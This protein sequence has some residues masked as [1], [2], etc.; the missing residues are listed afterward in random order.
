MSESGS[1]DLLKGDLR[2]SS[3]FGYGMIDT[4]IPFSV[5]A[6]DCPT[7]TCSATD[8][9]AHNRPLMDVQRHRGLHRT[10]RL[11]SRGNP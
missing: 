3:S 8:D 10:V 9:S 4:T 6:P 7:S 5:F 1:F 2:T 11:D